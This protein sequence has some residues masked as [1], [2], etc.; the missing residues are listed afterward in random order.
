MNHTRYMYM[1][2]VQHAFVFAVIYAGSNTEK[3]GLPTD[4]QTQCDTLVKYAY[5]KTGTCRVRIRTKSLSRQKSLNRNIVF[6]SRRVL[7]VKILK[8]TRSSKSLRFNVTLGLA[9]KKDLLRSRV[10]NVET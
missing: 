8:C 2:L 5:R 7:R 9:N 4:S 3:A 10:F 6:L 1:P